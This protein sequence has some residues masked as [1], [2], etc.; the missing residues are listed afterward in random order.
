MNLIVMFQLFASIFTFWSLQL[1][2]NDVIIDIVSVISQIG[3]SQ[4]FPVIQ[5]SHLVMFTLLLLQIAYIYK[6]FL[7]LLRK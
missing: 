2:I 6:R 7:Y 3:R 1:N 4:K 5:Q